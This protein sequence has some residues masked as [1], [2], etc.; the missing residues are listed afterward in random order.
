MNV[1]GTTI[2]FILCHAHI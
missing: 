2:F 1:A